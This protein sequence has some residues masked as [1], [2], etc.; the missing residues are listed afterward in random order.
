MRNPVGFWTQAKCKEVALCCKNKKELREKYEGAY[1]FAIKNNIL[2]DICSHMDT[3][4]DLYK[5]L[6]YGY[7]FEDNS[8]YIG[9]TCNSHRRKGEHITTNSS[10]VYQHIQK[11]GLEP[12]YIELTEYIN[13]TEAIKL[14]N[15]YVEF[16]KKLGF[17]ILNKVKTGSIGGNKIKWNYENCKIESKKYN[18]R[19]LFQK[20]S[21][22]AYEKSRKEGWL[23]E[24]FP[25]SKEKKPNGYWTKEKCLEAISKCK[26]R[27]EFVE[28]YSGAFFS[29]RKNNWL[30]EVIKN[31]GKEIQK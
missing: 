13:V 26:T 11:T 29:C 5:R 9:L 15:T 6:I 24:F 10:S 7:K 8:I 25:N 18:S 23:N 4:G 20:G 3:Y 14:E 19:F 22:K 12:I 27:K 21:G 30:K 31:L 2:Y 28:N 16:Y 17:T 1:K